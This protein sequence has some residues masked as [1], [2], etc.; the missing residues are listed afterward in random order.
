METHTSKHSHHLDNKTNTDRDMHV[1]ICTGDLPKY[2]NIL[3]FAVN[4]S[5]FPMFTRMAFLLL[6]MHGEVCWFCSKHEDAASVHDLTLSQLQDKFA[7]MKHGVCPRC[8]RTKFDMIKH[9]VWNLV[10]QSALVLGLRSGK[11]YLGI[12]AILYAEYRLQMLQARNSKISLAEHYGIDISTKFVCSVLGTPRINSALLEII[13]HIRNDS[14]WFKLYS[15]IVRM[16]EVKTGIVLFT[17]TRNHVQYH[18]NVHFYAEDILKLDRIRGRTRCVAYIDESSW[19]SDETGNF[20]DVEPVFKAA[21]VGTK[22]L[23]NT[24]RSKMASGDFD[25]PTPLVITATSPR[26]KNDL[27]HIL[28]ANSWFDRS[29][30]FAKHPTWEIN[31]KQSRDQLLG[32]SRDLRDLRDYACELPPE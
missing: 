20:I 30:Y 23:L 22:T 15:D 5:N 27:V 4:G 7:L 13:Q 25:I 24:S 17:N 1:D 16:H 31:A 18:N 26:C 11:A 32:E 29:I 12:L 10:N 19:I 9:G 2:D 14:S 8:R 3:D 28:E 6:D 21:V